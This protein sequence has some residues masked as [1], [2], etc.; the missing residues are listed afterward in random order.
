MRMGVF[1]NMRSSEL[2]RVAGIIDVVLELIVCVAIVIAGLTVIHYFNLM[3]ML[4]ILG[5]FLLIALVLLIIRIRVIRRMYK[6]HMEMADS[7]DIDF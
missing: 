7:R 1:K 5:M 2:K 3:Q 6:R 4:G